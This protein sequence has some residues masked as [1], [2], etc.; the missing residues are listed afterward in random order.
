MKYEVLVTTRAMRELKDNARWWGEHRSGGE[1]KRWYDGF[2]KALLSLEKNPARYPLARE[3]AKFP[4]EV[5]QFT[6]GLGRRSSHRAIFTIRDE[7]V[8]ILAIRHAA[9]EDIQPEE[10]D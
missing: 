9:R 2:L 3:H 8:L 6:Y 5:R 10:L 7:H 1:A 4:Y